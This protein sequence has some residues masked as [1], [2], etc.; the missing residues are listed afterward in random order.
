M[1]CRSEADVREDSEN[2]AADKTA[3]YF[4]TLLLVIVLTVSLFSTELLNLLFLEIF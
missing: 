4:L 1:E 3:F 2:N